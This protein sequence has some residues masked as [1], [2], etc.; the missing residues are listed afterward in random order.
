VSL[1]QTGI[2]EIVFAD[3]DAS[4]PDE[5]DLHVMDEWWKGHRAV[6]R[7]NLRPEFR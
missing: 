6:K 7:I 4:D 2:L 3:F 5:S 1:I